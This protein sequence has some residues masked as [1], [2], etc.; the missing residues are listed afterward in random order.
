MITFEPLWKSMKEKG[1]SQYKLI[2]EYKISTGQLDRL[3]K[4]GNVSTYT[5]NQLCKI[6]D[7]KLEDIAV[8]IKDEE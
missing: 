8:Y 1:I 5:L 4:N 3:R 7:C 6:L 2:K